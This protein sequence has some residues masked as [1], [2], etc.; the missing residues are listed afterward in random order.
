[1]CISWTNK[2]LG[3][4]NM[5]GATMKIGFGRL[6]LQDGNDSLPETSTRNFRYVLRNSPEEGNSHLLCGGSLNHARATYVVCLVY[7]SPHTAIRRIYSIKNSLRISVFYCGFQELKIYHVL[8]ASCYLN[9][10]L[11]HN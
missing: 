1:V 3:T 9:S 5:H 8:L 7:V 6:T 11:T 4:M 2:G 10:Y